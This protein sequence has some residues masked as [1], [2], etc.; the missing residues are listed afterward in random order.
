M[1]WEPNGAGCV[2]GGVACRSV[3]CMRS[4][5]VPL[6]SV[7]VLISTLSMLESSIGAS[8]I[9]EIFLSTLSTTNGEK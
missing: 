9:I 5:A 4:N 6:G 1:A 8:F 2:G 7:L 3:V